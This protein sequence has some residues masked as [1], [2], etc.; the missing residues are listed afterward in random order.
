MKRVFIV[1]LLIAVVLFSSVTTSA[2][3]GGN[4]DPIIVLSYLEY[5]LEELVNY[6]DNNI[7]SFSETTSQQAIDLENLNTIIE[8]QEKIISDLNFQI[9]N[10]KNQSGGSTFEVLELNIG[11][12]LIAEAGTEII[13]RS[14]EAFAIDN[15]IDGLSDITAAK[16]LKQGEVIPLNHL[17]IVPRSD[18]RG[19]YVESCV[20]LMIRGNYTIVES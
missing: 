1:L 18:G 14:G 3:P 8:D 12:K 15:G 10:I 13:I 11:Q 2:E 16:D 17:I 5:R 20:F 6:I 7:L 4:D 9:E 19:V